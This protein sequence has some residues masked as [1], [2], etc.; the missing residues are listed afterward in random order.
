MNEDFAFVSGR[1]L[2]R[3]QSLRLLEEVMGFLVDRESDYVASRRQGFL[4]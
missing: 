1:D 4:F 3:E 2:V